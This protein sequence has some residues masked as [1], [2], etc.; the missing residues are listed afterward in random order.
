MIINV[1]MLICSSSLWGI[2][3]YCVTS[4][5][6]RLHL[7]STGKRPSDRS[8]TSSKPRSLHVC[9]GPSDREQF[10]C[11][12][13]SRI[14]CRLQLRMFLV[15]LF[16]MSMGSKIEKLHSLSVWCH[17]VLSIQ[18]TANNTTPHAYD[19]TMC[20]GN[21]TTSIYI[22]NKSISNTNNIQ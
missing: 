3:F 8:S 4:E 18:E 7:A 5:R 11:L 20:V 17:M 15:G 13:T 22:F 1:Y 19:S 14:S 6:L 2:N 21:S 16:W 10:S 12:L 9:L